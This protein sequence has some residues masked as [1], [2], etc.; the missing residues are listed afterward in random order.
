MPI[1]L[2]S[3]RRAR[4]HANVAGFIVLADGRTYAASNSSTDAVVRAIAREIRDHEF[5]DWL[6]EQQSTVRGLGM[7]SIDVRDLAPQFRESFLNAIRLAFARV[8]SEGTES[9][10]IDAAE[11]WYE[12]FGDLVDMLNRVERGETPN[13]FNPHMH[14]VIPPRRTHQGPGWPEQR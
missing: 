1:H 10:G 12:R 7:T 11:G 9:L 3:C 4:H 13:E 5:R 8:S 14:D 6:L 2:A